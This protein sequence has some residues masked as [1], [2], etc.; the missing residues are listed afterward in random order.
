M[1]A[2]N[3]NYCDLVGLKVIRKIYGLH[4]NGKQKKE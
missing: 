1:P 2:S 4:D 3:G